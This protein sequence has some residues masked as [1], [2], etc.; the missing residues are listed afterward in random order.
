MGGKGGKLKKEDRYCIIM[1]DLHCCVAETNI[2]CK[3][4]VLQLKINF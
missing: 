1:A 2:I 4:I 3:A